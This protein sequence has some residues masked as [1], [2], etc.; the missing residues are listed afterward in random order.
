M[1]HKTIITIF[2]ALLIPIPAFAQEYVV[3]FERPDKVGAKYSFSASGGVLKDST[4]AV[5]TEVNS[6]TED[7]QIQ[8]AAMAEVLE[9]DEKGRKVKI[10]FTV[11]KFT[12]IEDSR[13]TELVPP[14]TVIIADRNQETSYSLQ[15]GSLSPSAQEALTLVID[16]AEPSAPSYD[17]LLGTT[18]PKQVG[19]SWALDNTLVA[20]ALQKYCPESE[21]ENVSGVAKIAGLEEIGGIEY[22]DIRA[23]LEAEQCLTRQ[24]VLTFDKAIVRV[25]IQGYVPVDHS[26]PIQAKSAMMNFQVVGK[27]TPDTGMEGLVYEGESQGT[28]QILQT[29]GL[30]GQ[31]L[32]EAL[33]DKHT[34]MIEA[35]KKAGAD[36]PRF[37]DLLP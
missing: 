23:E 10:A 20:K 3:K 32:Q 35:L 14:G 26:I 9:V 36:D 13:L 16:L 17:E 27:A 18:E 31:L 6:T 24:G 34:E 4:T 30:D 2:L 12:K 25:G 22:L 28:S 7:Y 5:D 19:E 33:N 37:Q 8:F 1:P 29:A 21:A 15:D 11:E